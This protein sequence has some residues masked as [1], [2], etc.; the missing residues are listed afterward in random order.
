MMYLLMVINNF[1]VGWAGCLFGPFKT[2]PPLVIDADAVLAFS[3]S[4]QGFKAVA[5]QYGKVSKHNGRL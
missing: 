4:F 1:H 2:D 3:V 5:G